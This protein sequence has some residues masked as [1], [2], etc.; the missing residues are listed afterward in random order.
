MLTK[1]SEVKRRYK[2]QEKLQAKVKRLMVLFLAAFFALIVPFYGLHTKAAIKGLEP[3]YRIFDRAIRDDIEAGSYEKKDDETVDYLAEYEAVRYDATDGLVSN[4]INDV[5]QTPDGYIWIG[6]YSGLYRYNGILFEPGNI[7]SRICNVMTLYVD[8]KG[9]LW[10]GTNDTGL[11][12][13]DSTTK[14]VKYFDYETEVGSGSIRAIGEDE[15]GNIYIGTVSYMTIIY[16]DFTTKIL[17]EYDSVVSVISLTCVGGTTMA[18]C[19]NGGSLFFLEDGKL[20]LEQKDY[21]TGIYYTQ[22][23][24]A[25]ADTIVAGTTDNI[26][27]KCLYK[28]G[29]FKI[30][31]KVETPGIVFFNKLIQEPNGNGWFFCAENG[32]GYVDSRG[33][34]TKLMRNGFDS[35]LTSCIIDNQGN[36]WFVSN[37]QGIIEFSK[38]PFLNVFVKAG[39][40]SAVVNCILIDHGE[41]YIGMDSGL[42]VLDANT[43]EQRNYDYIS[44]FDGIRIRHLMMDSQNNIW[45][46]TYGKD[47]LLKVGP[48]GHAISFT[49]ATGALG[50]RFRFCM[51]LSNGQV[52]AASN[53]GLNF[54]EGDKVVATIGKAEGLNAPQLLTMVEDAD[55]TVIVGSDGDGIY[56][57]KDGKIIGHIGSKE[58]LHTQVILRIVPYKDGYI[59]VTSNSMYYDD[60][61]T[62]KQLDRFPYTNCYD[63]HITDDN[64]AWISSSAGLYL[65]NADDLIENEQYNVALLD[66]SSGFNTSLTSNSWNALYNQD[67]LL[68]CCTD[69]VRQVSLKNYNSF[70]DNYLIDVNKIMADDAAVPIN[71]KGVY[72][73]PAGTMRV[74]I[75]ISILN[76][77][78]SN[79]LIK[80]YLEGANDD[81]M[82]VEQEG[83]T[84]LNY[85]NLP[86][87]DYTLHIQ[88]LDKNTHAVLRDQ[89]YRIYKNPRFFER[90]LVRMGLSII[91]ALL[92]A[93]F[94]WWVL[95]STVISKQY[96]LIREAKEEADRANSAKSRFVANMSHE[97]RTPINTII[98]MGEMILRE[99]RSLPIR[100][101][102]K[103]V[104]GYTTTIKRASE[105]LLAIVNDIL[106]MSKIESGKMNLVER[107]YDLDDLLKT[108]VA[109]IRVRSNEKDLL[110]ET[111]IDP[112][113]PR[114]LY[115]DDGKIKQVIMNL[116]TNAVKYTQEG[117]F[118][119]IMKLVKKDNDTCVIDYSV[120]DTGMGIKP[121]DMEK[122]F[123]PFERLDEKK[124]SGIQ[125]TGLGLNISR[126]FVELM[127]NEL[128]CE[129]TYGEGS[130]FYFSLVQKISKDEPIG[131]FTE[132]ET[133]DSDSAVYLPAF[134]APEA[135][136]LVVDDNE[137]NLQV[138][139]GL[140]KPTKLCIDTATSGKECLKRL[141][142]EQYELV[143]LDH[144]MPEMDG[145]ETFKRIREEGYELPVFALT[146]N[147]AHNGEAFYTD[148]GFNGY[149]EKPVNM[150][151]LEDTLKNNIPP[152]LLKAPDP[153]DYVPEE[154]ADDGNGAEEMEWLFS[155]DDLDVRTGLQNCGGKK[156]FMDALNTFYFTI[157]TKAEEIEKAFNEGDYE[158]YTIKVHALKSSARVIGASRLSDISAKMEEAGKS[159]N[160]DEIKNDTPTLLTLY[161][162]FS[163]KLSQLSAKAETDDRP[164][165]DED[166]IREAYDALKEFAAMMDYDSFE[167]VLN[168]MSAYNCGKEQNEKFE[169]LQ[170]MLKELNW[171]GIKE[172]LST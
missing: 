123:A 79:P 73:I 166:T 137:M 148:L 97:I 31:R 27:V 167:M 37:N 117:S 133:G 92:V 42:A 59:Y 91:V 77:C 19:T 70:D 170:R 75:R 58:G 83:V 32:L 138:L 20:T 130:E 146:A 129:S 63:V 88:V 105:T 29:R 121:E 99:D 30:L 18:G 84:P 9:R 5:A 76:Y 45:L 17:E 100:E 14:E 10:I 128:K 36:I 168:D 16:E 112:E 1:A 102:S 134:V 22:V 163:E 7:D 25:G 12:C 110:F 40:D 2:S 125:G 103:A 15:K 154:A 43:Y 161:R 39:L 162:E 156:E 165:C 131:V 85:T 80:Y 104:V 26:L 50:G 64:I 136:I 51:E 60:R 98:G 96:E 119:L 87:G 95:R 55:G 72:E 56:L 132:A 106:D 33:K 145:L 47:G 111:S 172:Q 127:G 65:V 52:L 158:L 81:G 78:L 160:L 67:E 120:I 116:L 107:D 139:K 118:R 44:Y 66:Y 143:L 41:M 74:Q 113:I 24:G 142:E 46:C 89:Q 124:N 171:D 61:K 149:L 159:G 28:D 62:I 141:A 4:E 169:M 101:Y 82:T 150:K 35:S 122:L 3:E 109:M 94:V 135:K 140:L 126:Q 23:A 54:I 157:D 93:Q 152:E 53:K 164:S 114:Y 34:L 147:A 48:D 144:M 115:G 90:N 6:T 21:D 151:A 13:Y 153:N 71:E 155:V 69:G 86:Y 11:F 38:N 108:I 57:V 8:S 49:E 68:L